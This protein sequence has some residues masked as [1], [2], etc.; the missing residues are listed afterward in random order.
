[1]FP[2]I[3][4]QYGEIEYKKIETE[5]LKVILSSPGETPQLVLIGVY[6]SAGVFRKAGEGLEERGWACDEFCKA[7]LAGGPPYPVRV[8]LMPGWAR[9]YN[10]LK[11]LILSVQGEVPP[12]PADG[13]MCV[14]S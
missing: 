4:E 12:A 14:I 11:G 1:V 8:C 7:F 5:I 13:C 2:P 10:Y 3:V 9:R 6:Q